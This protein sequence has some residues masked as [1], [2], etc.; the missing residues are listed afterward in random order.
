[1]TT[2][3]ATVEERERENRALHREVERWRRVAIAN[4]GQLDQHGIELPGAPALDG[5]HAED[6]PTPAAVEIARLQ[7]ALDQANARSRHWRTA[8]RHAAGVPGGSVRKWAHR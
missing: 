5:E 7:V 3:G 4:A 8:Y 6:G 1:M 2:G